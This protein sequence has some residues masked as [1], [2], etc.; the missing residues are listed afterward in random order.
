[1][2]AKGVRGI[3]CITVFDPDRRHSVITTPEPASHPDVAA[4]QSEIPAQEIET[5]ILDGRFMQQVKQ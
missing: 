1:M 2:T 5:N 3:V 4:W